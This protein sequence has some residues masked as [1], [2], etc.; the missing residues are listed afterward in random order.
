MVDVGHKKVTRRQAVARG[1]V[2]LSSEAF[3]LVR[4]NGVKKGDV[5]GVAQMAGIQAAKKT[6]ELV[7]LCHPLPL[8][9]I[10]VDLRLEPRSSRV[11]VEARARARAVTGVE[12][13]ALTAVAVACLTVYDMVKGVDRAACIGEIRLVSKQGGK[14]GFSG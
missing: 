2:T 13:E 5:L 8:D 12:M 3:D 4:R 9:G 14:S 10:D 11:V 1:S 6:W 7:P